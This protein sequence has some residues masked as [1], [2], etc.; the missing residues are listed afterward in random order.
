MKEKNEKNIYNWGNDG[1]WKDNSLPKSK[2]KVA[3]RSVFRWRL[4]LGCRSILDRLDLS[5]CEVHTISLLCEET[6]LR[7]RICKDVKAGIRTVEVLE[8]S[9]A[10]IPLY[11][12]LKTQKIDTTGKSVETVVDEIL[13]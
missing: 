1:G 4:V 6:E 11:K 3:K 5:D 12:K 13:K 2:K 7:K 9:A 10:R 8:R